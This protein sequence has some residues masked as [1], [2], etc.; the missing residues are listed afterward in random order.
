MRQLFKHEDFQFGYEIVL[1]SA[2]RGYADAGEVLSTVGRIK[3]GD[4]RC[5]G[6]GMERHR[7]ATG[8]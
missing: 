3:D 4:Y 8:G 2:Y 6:A 1:G 5:L 7:R